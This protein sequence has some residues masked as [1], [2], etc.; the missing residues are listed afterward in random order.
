MIKKRVSLDN[1]TKTTIFTF[2]SF[3]LYCSSIRFVE[4]VR[5]YN[6]S[7]A[8]LS[9]QYRRKVAYEPGEQYSSA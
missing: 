4:L 5:L 8:A 3:M 9:F 6:L 7:N 1:Q 2:F